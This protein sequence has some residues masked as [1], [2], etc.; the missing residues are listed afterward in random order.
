[1]SVLALGACMLVACS[2]E[3]DNTPGRPAPP[4][5]VLPIG[6]KALVDYTNEDQHGTIGITVTS[7]VRGDRADLGPDPGAESRTGRVPYY[8]HAVI[9]NESDAAFEDMDA[10]TFLGVQPSDNSE[11]AH[12][13]GVVEGKCIPGRATGFAVRGAE[14]EICRMIMVSPTATVTATYSGVQFDIG[15][16]QPAQHYGNNPIRWQ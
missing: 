1:M 8:L 6:T 5:T 11:T 3:Q 4:G 15:E 9:S 14:Y 2:P 10:E 13:S 7:I 16:P 12:Y